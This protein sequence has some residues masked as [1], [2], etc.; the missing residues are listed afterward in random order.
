MATDT[1][2]GPAQ[3]T[4]A[5]ERI[6]VVADDMVVKTNG[7]KEA[8]LRAYMKANHTPCDHGAD[9]E[10]EHGACTKCATKTVAADCTDCDQ[11]AHA[12][13]SDCADGDCDDCSDCSSGGT[14][15]QSA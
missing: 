13:C 9:C 7:M 11:I 1:H 10:D 2:D 12:E 3:L 14:C 5:G 6:E 8:Q 4:E 15:S